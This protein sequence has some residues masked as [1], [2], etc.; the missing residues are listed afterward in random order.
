LP[1]FEA[2]VAELNRHVTLVTISPPHSA[3]TDITFR[4]YTIPKVRH[5]G[6]LE[7]RSISIFQRINLRFRNTSFL[8]MSECVCFAFQNSAV[9][10]HL[11]QCHRDPKYWK[12][13]ESFK[14]ERFLDDEGNFVNRE[15]YIPF[16]SGKLGICRSLGSYW[17]SELN[18]W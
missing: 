5:Y 7:K 17:R 15:G 3:T 1:Y 8:N 16:S 10:G 18:T 12:D 9:L 11:K 13:P 6:K 2:V 4:G 14:P